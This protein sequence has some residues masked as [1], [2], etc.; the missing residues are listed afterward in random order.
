MM[1]LSMAMPRQ[2]GFTGYWTGFILLLGLGSSSTVLGDEDPDLRRR[3]L[4]EAPRAWVAL[5]TADGRLEVAGTE[6]SNAN[7]GQPCHFHYAQD[8]GSRFLELAQDQVT[9]GQ[10]NC[11]TPDRFF[12]LNRTAPGG[13]YAISGLGSGA[14]DPRQ[15]AKSRKVLEDRIDHFYVPNRILPHAVNGLLMS[16]LL[17]TPTARL[18]MV[19]PAKKD[20]VDL[21]RVTFTTEPFDDPLNAG[22]QVTSEN[23]IFL[24]PDKSWAVQEALTKLTNGYESTTWHVYGEDEVGLP[25]IKSY[26]MQATYPVNGV[27]GTMKR[28][29][30]YTK[31]SRRP[32]P[33]SAFTLT[34]FGLPELERPLGRGAVLRPELWLLTLAVLLAAVAVALGVYWSRSRRTSVDAS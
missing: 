5:E 28:E 13:P 16:T 19:E 8:G 24:R 7:S 15:V 9:A 1:R 10:V 21:V 26:R 33:P 18:K 29:I 32:I 30:T 14:S 3:F 25:T 31:Y 20:G 12:V 2:C 4:A 11:L 23:Q 34:G 6:L 17:K 22:K 27:W